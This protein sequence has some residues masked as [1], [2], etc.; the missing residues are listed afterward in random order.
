MDG[1]WIDGDAMYA[2][3]FADCDRLRGFG[4]LWFSESWRVGQSRVRSI[5]ESEKRDFLRELRTMD[6]NW[7]SLKENRCLAKITKERPNITIEGAGPR[8]RTRMKQ[9]VVGL[10]LDLR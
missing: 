5:R 2:A 7:Q 10:Y 1:V 6:P 8:M 9:Q 3:H 4:D